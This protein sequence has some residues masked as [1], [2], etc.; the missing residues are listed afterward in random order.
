MSEVPA[1]FVLIA[2]TSPAHELVG[3]FYEKMRDDGSRI[4]GMRVAH[5]HLNR[6]GVI[7]GGLVCTFCDFAM[8]QATMR[9]LEPGR[10]YVTAN[11]SADFAGS[12]NEGEWIEAHAE[13]FRSG[14]RVVFVNCF[15]YRGEQ[16][17]AR[18]SGT[19]VVLT[20]L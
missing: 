19:F 7:H 3:P 1:G 17:I 10:K 12:A 2:P 6:I 14:R 4:I 13:V 16:R 8:S 15:V 9:T 5:Q 18:A 20:P 11:L